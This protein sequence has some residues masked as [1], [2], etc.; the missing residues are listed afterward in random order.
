MNDCVKCGACV[1]VCPVYR[2][3]GRET[4]SARGRN[5]LLDVL[6]PERRTR[7]FTEIFSKCLLCGACR[8]VCPREVDTP[9]RIIA[10]RAGF[11]AISGRSFVNFIARRAMVSPGLLGGITVAKTI[12]ARILPV[13]SGLRLRLAALDPAGLPHP[14]DVSYIDDPDRARTSG[15]RPADAGV[16]YFVGCHANYLQPEIGRAVDR[17][18]SRCGRAAPSAPAAQTCCGLAAMAGGNLEEARQLARKNIAAFADNDQLI[19]T[20]CGSCYSHLAFYPELLADDDQW[21]GRAAAFAVRLREFSTYFL[22]NLNPGPDKRAAMPGTRCQ[23]LYHDPC[24]LRFHHRIIDPPR[25][26]LA[27]LPEVKLVELPDGP[28]CCGQG[29]LFQL[30]HPG[31]SLAIREQLLAEFSSLAVET[32]VTTCSGCLLQWRQGLAARGNPARAEHLALFL[33]RLLATV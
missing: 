27:R 12:L 25:Q 21:R 1:P 16:G 28:R 7:L 32:V 8:D 33:D 24:H 29:G 2:V 20:S 6:P 9:G 31:M 19:L 30:A 26:L 13:E 14:A 23:V 3:T 5:Q 22:D 17:L 10:A 15:D 4:F 18:L 11:A